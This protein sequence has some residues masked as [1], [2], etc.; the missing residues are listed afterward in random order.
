MAM[1][2]RQARPQDEV[3]LLPMSD[4]GDGFG[5][6]LSGLLDA[7]PHVVETVDAAHRPINAQ[8]TLNLTKHLA[9]VES[10]RVVGLAMLPKGKFHP[11]QLDTFGLGK[12]L[13]AAGRRGVEK[14]IIGIGGSAT[15]D[16][17]F[18]LARALD[19]KFYS[20][21]GAEIREWWQLHKLAVITRPQER[22]N[23]KVVVAVDVNNPLLGK[24]G[25]SQ[26]Y[27]PQKGL[28]P[29]DLPLAEK[30]LKRLSEVAK[31]SLGV[32]LAKVSGAGAAGGLG[33]GLMAFTDAQCESGFELFSVNSQLEKRIRESDMVITGEGAIDDQTF[34]GK[35]VG[36]IV[37]LCKKHKVPCL[38]LAGRIRNPSKA[39]KFFFGM[40]ALVED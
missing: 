8:W 40:D 9:I 11:F 31:E 38:G 5:E 36:R 10:A 14:C 39:K 3:D 25:C 13:R 34:M 24:R 16:G 4:G 26:V 23:M 1:G 20:Q 6:V 15:N 7:Q 35:G 22:L 33:F 18:G 2:W 12:I 32:N 19:W 21:G 28:R 37:E 30:C 17:G 27:G 29:E